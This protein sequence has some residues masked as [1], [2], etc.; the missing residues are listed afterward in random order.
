MIYVPID[1]RGP[2]SVKKVINIQKGI[3]NNYPEIVF[4]LHSS[5]EYVDLG[6]FCELSAAVTNTDLQSVKFSG[7]LDI[8]NP[9]RGQILCKLN[10]KDFSETGINTLTV[11]CNCA[12]FTVSFQTTIFVQS[13]SSSLLDCL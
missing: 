11:L 10:Y 6:D 7:E 8:M 12:D 5:H 1:I 9:H 4:E 2:I 3:T 13:V